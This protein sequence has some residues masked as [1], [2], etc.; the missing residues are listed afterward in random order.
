MAFRIDEEPAQHD[1]EC[2]HPDQRVKQPARQGGGMK[3]GGDFGRRRVE[4]LSEAFCRQHIGRDHQKQCREHD[5]RHL[6][7]ADRPE[8][9][10]CEDGLRGCDPAEEEKDY[11]ALRVSQRNLQNAVR[12]QQDDQGKNECRDESGEPGEK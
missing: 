12:G 3:I 8:A 2:R 6:P 4:K 11:D 7:R 1:G 5:S 9:V 10:E